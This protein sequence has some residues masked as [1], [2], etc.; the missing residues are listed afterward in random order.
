M[1]QDQKRRDEVMGLDGPKYIG[2]LERFEELNLEQLETL[3][4]ED[5]AALTDAQNSAPT[6]GD[7]LNF[8]KT[9]PEVLAHG[10][11]IGGGRTDYRLRIE[12]LSFLGK[13]PEELKTDF[14]AFCAQASDLKIEKDE[15]YSWWD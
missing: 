4:K 8:M 6:T 12:G 14:T 1:N 3:L 2:G 5:F 7:F 15:L 9:H 11:V 13:A 10:Y